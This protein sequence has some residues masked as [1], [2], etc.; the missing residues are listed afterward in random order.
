M[1]IER[2]GMDPGCVL[3]LA[4]RDGGRLAVDDGH[5][6]RFLVDRGRQR[7]EHYERGV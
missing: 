1:A 3:D 4:G 5:A 6:R 2:N 7:L